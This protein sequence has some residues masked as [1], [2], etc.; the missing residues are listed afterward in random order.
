MTTGRRHFLDLLTEKRLRYVYLVTGLTAI[1]WDLFSFVVPIYGA[2]IGLSATRIGAI[3]GVFALATFIVRL[4]MPV[5][6]RRFSPWQ[7]LLTALAITG[8]GYLLFP[9]VHDLTLLMLL[10]FL[11]GLGLGT[12]QPMVLA[13]LYSGTPPGRVG[14]GLGLRQTL[15][16]TAQTAVPLFFGAAGAAIGILPVFWVIAAAMFGGAWVV[17]AQHQL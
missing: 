16:N 7:V 13:L 8:V 11:L 5:L 14:E 10:A 4:A 17:R 1:G 12:S 15:I 2:A 3:L 9:L 6:A